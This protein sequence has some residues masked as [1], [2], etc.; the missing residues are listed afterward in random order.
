[1]EVSASGSHVRRKRTAEEKTTLQN[2]ILSRN[3]V[4]ERGMVQADVMIEPFRFINDIFRENKWRSLFTPVDAYPRLV[5]EFYY[6]IEIIKKTPE[7]CFKTKVLGK[8]LTINAELI[9]EITRIPLTN[10]KAAPFLDTELQPSKVDIMAVLN[11][12]GQF[13]WDDNKSKIPIGHVRASERL[14]TRIVLQNIW[15]IS[16]HSHVPLDR[17]IFI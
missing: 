12:G 16:R 17:T 5:R 10:G 7:L 2:K 13:E 6:N 1:V 14:L 3:I 8:T 15:P 9:S 4:I 11:P